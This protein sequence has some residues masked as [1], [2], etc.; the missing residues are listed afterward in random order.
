MLSGKKQ[1]H[2]RAVHRP[3]ILERA[4]AASEENGGVRV[5]KIGLRIGEISGVETDALTFGLEALSKDTSFEGARVE[6]ELLQAQAALHGLRHRVRARGL[7]RPPARPATATKA[8]CI[9][10][11]ELDVTFFELEDPPCA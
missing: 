5:T 1:S 10:G 9:A 2:A 4:K 3:A 11:N 6:V 7:H 8:T